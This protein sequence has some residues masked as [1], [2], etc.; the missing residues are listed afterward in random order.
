[1]TANALKGDRER[2]I[3]AGMNDYVSKPINRVKLLERIAFWVGD[4]QDA[5]TGERPGQ[6]GSDV[7]AE[8]GDA[9]AAAP[10]G[11]PDRLDGVAGAVGGQ[12]QEQASVGTPTMVEISG[13]RGVEPAIERQ[14]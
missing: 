8:L 5:V 4:E 9:A 7:D 1:M 3:Q 11:R 10:E 14:P 13:D 6:A 12:K 2:Y